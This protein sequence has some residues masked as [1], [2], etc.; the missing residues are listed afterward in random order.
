MFESPSSLVL[1]GELPLEVFVVELEL[2]L[3]PGQR[4][5]LLLVAL[6]LLEQVLLLVV[7]LHPAVGRVTPEIVQ[8]L[9]EIMM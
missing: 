4:L 7:P 1:D 6:D 8:G 2:L 5:Q 3:L 9:P